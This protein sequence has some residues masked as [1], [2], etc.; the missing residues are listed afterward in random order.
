MTCFSN[1]ANFFRG[2]SV[3]TQCIYINSMYIYNY[4]YVLYNIVNISQIY[5]IVYSVYY[6]RSIFIFQYYIIKVYFFIFD[7]IYYIF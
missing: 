2:G 7:N 4:S 3:Y 6:L 5:W 1:T